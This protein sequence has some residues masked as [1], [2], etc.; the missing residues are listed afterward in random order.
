M[1]DG[2]PSLETILNVRI[3][4]QNPDGTRRPL[5]AQL[6]PGDLLHLGPTGFEIEF[7]LARAEATA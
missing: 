7:A 4:Q 1:L 6:R 3:E 2:V 5:P